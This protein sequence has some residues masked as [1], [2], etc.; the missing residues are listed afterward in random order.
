MHSEGKMQEW[1]NWPA[2]KASK[3]PKGF[4]GSNPL[5]SAKRFRADRCRFMQRFFLF[6]FRKPESA[7]S[8]EIMLRRRKR[9]EFQF[10]SFSF[11]PS[12][13]ST[14]PRIRNRCVLGCATTPTDLR[15]ERF[16]SEAARSGYS[17]RRKKQQRQTRYNDQ[18]ENDR[19]QQ[20]HFSFI[21]AFQC[22]QSLIP[23]PVAFDMDCAGRQ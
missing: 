5:L 23:S 20:H 14:K 10:R 7:E 12:R 2:W 19:K 3:P 11:L 18:Q 17:H 8:I 1:L 21:S 15:Q 9:A 13:L 4:R 6:D 16:C 22:F